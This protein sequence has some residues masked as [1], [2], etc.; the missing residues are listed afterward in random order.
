MGIA[1]GQ[2]GRFRFG[3]RDLT[4]NLALPF[5]A[6][7]KDVIRRVRAGIPPS[8]DHSKKKENDHEQRRNL[9]VD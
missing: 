3:I 9:G 4:G 6:T 8:Q 7:R 1:K 2:M 5:L